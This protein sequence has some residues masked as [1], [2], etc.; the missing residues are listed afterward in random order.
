MENSGYLRILVAYQTLYNHSTDEI[1]PR[2]KIRCLSRLNR[3]DPEDENSP[4]VIVVPHVPSCNSLL[5]IQQLSLC[6]ITTRGIL[7]LSSGSSGFGFLFC[8][9][10]S[11]PLH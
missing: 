7:T 9:S 8:S 11:A 4:N 1:K 3:R 2:E 10:S 6:Y 5:E